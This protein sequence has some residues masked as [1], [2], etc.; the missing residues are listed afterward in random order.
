MLQK[1]RQP[2]HGGYKTI[3]ERW[4]KDDTASLCQ[5]LGGLRSSS[6]SMTNL[7]WKTTPKIATR[8]ERTRNE[9]SWVLSLNEEGVQGPLNQRPDFVEAKGAFKT[10]HDE[11]VKETS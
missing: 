8:E 7:H 10:L 1:A 9:K 5:I 2:K 4:H 3:L 6:C 11:H